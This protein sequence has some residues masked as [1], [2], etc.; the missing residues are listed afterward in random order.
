MVEQSKRI[1][2]TQ[3]ENDLQS[4]ESA[5]DVAR[6][7]RKPTISLNSNFGLVSY[8]TTFPAFGDWRRNWTVGASLSIP[9]LTGGRIAADEAIAKAG[10]TEQQARLSLTRELAD[11]DAASTRAELVAA[12][13]AWEASAGTIQQAARAYEI[14]EL[15]Y[16]EGL[17]TQLELSDSRLLL[18]QAQVNRSTAARTLQVA[19]V[20]FALLP[21]LPLAVG[22]G[23]SVPLPVTPARTPVPATSPVTTGT[24][25]RSTTGTTGPSGA[26]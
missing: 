14:A 7:Q 21:Q 9:I 10:V 15:R 8:P 12:R 11:L 2:I 20:R 24:T 18:A 22:A 5:V 17:S 6:S 25:Q 16:R 13:A 4:Q 23:A 26:Q 19:R 1:A 3:A